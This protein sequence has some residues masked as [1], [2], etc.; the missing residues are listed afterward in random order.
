MDDQNQML[1]LLQLHGAYAYL[2]EVHINYGVRQTPTDELRHVFVSKLEPFQPT[3]PI[4]FPQ[5]S[6]D[7]ALATNCADSNPTY[8][9]RL[10]GALVDM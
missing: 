7:Y 9:F 8:G 3:T 4:V 2:G 6:L 5:A 10:A 1:L